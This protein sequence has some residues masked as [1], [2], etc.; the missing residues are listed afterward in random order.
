MTSQ[1]SKEQPQGL[2]VAELE[3]AY[4]LIA[5]AIDG[6]PGASEA[7]F[8]ARLVL[9]LAARHTSLTELETAIRI[10]QAAAPKAA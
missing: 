6:T 7:D 9:T 1:S 5:A 2:S 8:L 4:A 3:H 10:A